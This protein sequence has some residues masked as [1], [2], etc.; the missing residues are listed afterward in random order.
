M[1]SVTEAKRIES[2]DVLRGFALLGILLLNIIGFG[3]PS[4]AYSNPG[5]DLAD[6]SVLDI[7]AWGAIEITAEGAMRTLFSILF[8]AGIVLFTEGRAR[9]GVL[10]YR[11]TFLLFLF[12]LFDAYILL[13]NGDILMTYAFAGFLLYWLRNIRA[14]RMLALAGLFIVLISAENAIISS[15]LKKG[16]EASQVVEASE[17]PEDLSPALRASAA[18]WKDMVHDF[19]PTDDE[20]AD[21]I[22]KR[23]AGYGSAFHWNIKKQNN[24]MTFVIPVFMLWDSFAMMLLGMALYKFGVLQGDR[25]PAF[26]RT[27]MISGFAVGLLVNSYEVGRAFSSDFDLFKT[28]AQMQPTYHIGRLGMAFGYLGLLCLIVK[29]GAWAGLRARLAATGRMA[30]TNYLMHSVICLFIF[31]GAGFAL[32]GHV[33]RTQLYPFVLAIW[34]LQLILSPWWLARYQYGPAEWL[35]RALTYGTKPP[36]RRK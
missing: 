27:L 5:F 2:L 11:R 10:H 26:Y 3:M 32:V 34:I 36:F 1:S 12:G 17:N 29:S 18:Q 31:T 33:T 14:S 16:F 7:F 21:E 9:A 23:Q 8:G 28:F 30:L 25:S 24:M 15:E 19:T 4:A 22:Q 6:G 13:W 20:V 35:W